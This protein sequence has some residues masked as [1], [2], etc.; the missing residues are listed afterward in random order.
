[1]KLFPI[2]FSRLLTVSLGVLLVG[3]LI[4]GG[5]GL[6]A[7]STPLLSHQGDERAFTVAPQAEEIHEQIISPRVK[8]LHLKHIGE[9]DDLVFADVYFDEHR[10][11]I[12]TH[13]KNVFFD[14]AGLLAEEPQWRLQIEGYCDPRGPS[15]YNFARAGSHLAELTDFLHQLGVSS[16]QI[17]TVNFGQDPVTCPAKSE[18]CREDNLRAEKI[19]PMLSVERTKRGCLARLRL[20]SEENWPGTRQVSENLS[21]LQRIQ[22]AS[23]SAT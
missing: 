1:L 15:A 3:A 19:F 16:Y 17:S 8:S 22:L 13:L 2:S 12:D 6:A 21:S 10:R 23:P 20:M 5:Y 7:D 14:L 11:F 9:E 18:R 4:G